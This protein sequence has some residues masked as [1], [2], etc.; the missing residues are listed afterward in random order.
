M[1]RKEIL[2]N[3]YTNVCDE[4]NRLINSNHSKVE[5]ITT[6]QY[7]DKYLKPGSKLL[8]VGAGTGRYSLHYAEQGYEVNAIEF[9][10]HN[11][12]ILESKIKK[13]MKIKAEQGDAV[14][15]SRF[16]DNTFDVTLILGPLYHLYNLEDQLQKKAEL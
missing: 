9:V 10:S 13:D 11:I 7:I 16:A 2:N 3:F 12:K 15:L 14:D 4:D 6:I 5:F 1:L 8:E